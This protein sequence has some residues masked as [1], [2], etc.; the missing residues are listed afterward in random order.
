MNIEIKKEE[1]NIFLYYS[2]DEVEWLKE[3]LD[4]Y[5]IKNTFL[6]CKNKTEF[7]ENKVKVELAKLIDDYYLFDKKIL[8]IKYDLFFYKDIDLEYN[9]FFQ[10][11][12]RSPISIFYEIGKIN[13]NNQEIYVGGSQDNSISIKIFKEMINKFPTSYELQRYK[14]ARINFLIG[15]YFSNEKSYAEKYYKYLEKKNNK[16]QKEIDVLKGVDFELDLK[17]VSFFKDELNKFLGSSVGKGEKDW[18][19]LILEIIKF[20]YPKYILVIE[21]LKVKDPY[22]DDKGKAKTNT[23]KIDLALL[24]I[25][26]TIDVVEIK[27]PEVKILSAGEYR[28]NFYPL[29]EL[30]ATVLQLEKYIFYLNKGGFKLEGELNKKY[31][32]ILP[33]GFSIKITNPQGII[34][35]GRNKTWNDRQKRDFEVIKRKYKNLI[36]ILTY[37][38]LLS[39]LDNLYAILNKSK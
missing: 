28:N 5:K 34:I 7:L 20:L 35:A 33:K 13:D 4:E 19:K 38:D 32:K 2:P 36:D 14:Y 12:Y 25:D 23:R 21:E 8:D 6:V 24:D 3:R 26:G 9:N 10:D 22:Y 29:K 27:V 30:S 37:D 11:N 17:K 18:Q 31:K 39:R 1:G 15:E 16:K